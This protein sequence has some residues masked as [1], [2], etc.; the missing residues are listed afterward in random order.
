MPRREV[1]IT[2][3]MCPDELLDTLLA[4][5]T[6]GENGCLEWKGKKNDT[7]YGRI[8]IHYDRY[9]IHRVVYAAANGYN[10]HDL[11]DLKETHKFIL[12]TCDNKICINPEHLYNGDRLD[13]VRDG[14]ANGKR[15]GG[16]LT[17]RGL[18]TLHELLAN[19]YSQH[20]AARMLGIS[21]PYISQIVNGKRR[22]AG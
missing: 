4:H 16:H 11:D 10:L 22:V 18:K 13:N 21:Q 19:G 7:G 9:K 17:R 3:D 15:V 6:P 12:H 8:S 14:V 5:T 1:K 2:F 20:S